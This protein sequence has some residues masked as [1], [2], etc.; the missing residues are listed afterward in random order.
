MSCFDKNMLINVDLVFN[1]DTNF[2]SC[3][4]KNMLLNVDLVFNI[5]YFCSFRFRFT[6]TRLIDK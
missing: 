6:H 1:I 4:N 3:F 2:M 5:F